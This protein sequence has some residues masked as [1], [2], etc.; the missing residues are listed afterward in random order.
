M[1]EMKRFLRSKS[2]IIGTLAMPIFFLLSLSFGIGPSVN[3][4]GIAKGVRYLDFLVPGIIGMN[5]LFSSMFGGLSVLWDKEF[6][7]LKEILVAPVRRSS[8][9][10]G[11]ISGALTTTLIQGVLILI[12]SFALGFK[13]INTFSLIS[14]LIFM[15]LIC[16]G[17][18]GAGIAFASI[19]SDT[20]GFSLITQ[21]IVFPIFLLS[22]ALFPLANLPGWIKWLTMIDPLTYGIDGLRG[23]LIGISQ[24]YLLLDFSVLLVFDFLMVFLGTWLFSKT[25]V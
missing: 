24:F 1:R 11:R 15:I 25:E 16:I 13:I 2:R 4:G 7:F 6:G 21:F 20:Q 18:I 10:L 23:S 19:L 14:A 12:I 5:M 3:L 9:V 22:G 8:I 17:F